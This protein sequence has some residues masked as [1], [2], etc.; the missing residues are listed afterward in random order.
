M[1]QSRG[2]GPHSGAS[3]ADAPRRRTSLSPSEGLP[4]RVPRADRGAGLRGLAVVYRGAAG[5]GRGLSVAPHGPS[6]GAPCGRAPLL[7]Q[8][9][10]STG[11]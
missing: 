11:G 9:V 3:K 7:D 10:N 6:L 4:S 1:A 8:Q 2:P 5:A